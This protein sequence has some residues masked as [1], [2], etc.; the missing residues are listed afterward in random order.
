M[1]D[2]MLQL[3][4]ATQQRCNFS[5]VYNVRQTRVSSADLVICDDPMLFDRQCR[6]SR[7]WSVTIR[8]G[9]EGHTMEDL[10]GVGAEVCSSS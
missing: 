2:L 1:T 6:T 5:Q 4:T 7:E 8:A 3:W 9:T 10:V